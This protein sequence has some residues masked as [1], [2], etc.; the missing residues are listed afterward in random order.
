[1]TMVHSARD[2]LDLETLIGP[3]H[4][5][6]PPGPPVSNQSSPSRYDPS[7]IHSNPQNSHHAVVYLIIRPRSRS[8][9]L[10][11]LR[12]HVTDRILG[13]PPPTPMPHRAATPHLGLPQ[14]VDKRPSVRARDPDSD[15]FC[16]WNL[17]FLGL[18]QDDCG[19]FL[20]LP[21]LD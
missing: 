7:T 15:L 19:A 3:R 14:P 18:Y 20:T 9:M 12:S 6:Y 16:R 10:P 5:H 21:G 4:G 11:P 13:P 1:M 17:P 8:H 2:A